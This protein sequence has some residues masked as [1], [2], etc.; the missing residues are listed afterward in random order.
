M[1]AYDHARAIATNP[2]GGIGYRGQEGRDAAG[3]L[4]AEQLE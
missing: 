1:I 2:D 3:D 4:L